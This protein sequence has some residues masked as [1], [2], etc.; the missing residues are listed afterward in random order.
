M[1]LI[2]RHQIATRIFS[3]NVVQKI[4]CNRVGA[5]MLSAP[6]HLGGVRQNPRKMLSHCL[7]LGQGNA[8]AYSKSHPSEI[9]AGLGVE[10][11]VG[12]LIGA[13]A[14]WQAVNPT[15]V[16]LQPDRIDVI[17]EALGF[18][19]ESGEHNASSS[20]LFPRLFH[21]RH[22]SYIFIQRLLRNGLFDAKF[23]L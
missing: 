1:N 5:P 11:L 9:S 19:V 17:R 14:D 10:P 21:K 2:L 23:C 7:S 16:M 8:K 3:A 4:G 15:T 20:V 18:L 6:L 22:C 12:S 13:G